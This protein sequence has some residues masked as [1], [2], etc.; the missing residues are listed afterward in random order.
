MPPLF[1]DQFSNWNCN[2]FFNRPTISNSLSDSGLICAGSF[3]PLRKC[4]FLAVVFDNPIIAFISSLLK[5]SGPIAIFLRIRTIVITSFNRMVWRWS[6]SHVGIKSYQRIAP[7]VTNRN[8]PGTVI[9]IRRISRVIATIFHVIPDLAFRCRGKA[10]NPF[11]TRSSFSAITSTALSEFQSKNLLAEAFLFSA[12]ALAKPSCLMIQRA[13]PIKSYQT[14]KS[15]IRQILAFH[16][17]S[18]TWHVDARQGGCFGTT[19]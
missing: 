11:V 7:S 10:V 15:L 9:F 19:S 12:V 17:F 5:R 13:I 4:Q 1:S 8:S 16:I 18:C 3:G 14:T 2:R 6:W